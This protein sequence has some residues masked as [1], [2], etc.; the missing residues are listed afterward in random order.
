MKISVVHCTQTRN[1]GPEHVPFIQGPAALQERLITHIAAGPT[2]P[3]RPHQNHLMP[4]L[5]AQHGT[6]RGYIVTEVSK[7]LKKFMNLF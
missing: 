3:T 1:G 2:G 5:K 7:H 4:G 6:Q